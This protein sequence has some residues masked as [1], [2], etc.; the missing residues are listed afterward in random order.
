ML[1]F[2]YSTLVFLKIREGV[3]T[4]SNWHLSLLPVTG[5]TVRWYGEDA[6]S[7]TDLPL[8]RALERIRSLRAKIP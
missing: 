5:Q 4:N 3:P 8:S 7:K 6:R 1:L 2:L